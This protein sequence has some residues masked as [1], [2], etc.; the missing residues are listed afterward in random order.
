MKALVPLLACWMLGT[1]SPSRAQAVLFSEG[2]ENGF[3]KWNV[4]GLWILQSDTSPCGTLA[5][6][7]PEGQ[8]AAYYG[9]FGSCTYDIPLTANS[10]ELTLVD[11]VQ[12][13]AAGPAASLRCWTMHETEDCGSSGFDLFEIDISTN[14]GSSW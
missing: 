14:G 9:I 7:Y 4:T 2:F 8:N 1:A 6:P 11:P 10:G 5:A 12:I 3:T 13:P